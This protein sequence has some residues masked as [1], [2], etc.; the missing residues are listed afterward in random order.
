MATRA[1]LCLA[2]ILSASLSLGKIYHALVGQAEASDASWGGE[3]RAAA[4]VPAGDVDVT[5]KDK[6]F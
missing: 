5:F 4:D 2:P 1:A 3:A 6:R